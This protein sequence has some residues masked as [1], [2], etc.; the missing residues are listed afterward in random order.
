[1]RLVG[2]PRRSD[3]GKEVHLGGIAYRARDM[4][5]EGEPSFTVTSKARSW[6][7]YDYGLP[8]GQL[9]L[10]QAGSLQGFP[11]AYPWAGSRTA[12]FEQIANA[13]PPPMAAA[14]LS[15]LIDPN[16]ATP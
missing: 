15:T 7:V 3:G 16:G 2:F 14:L 5:D 9:S 8:T 11:A 1:M 13:V 4:R 10:A 6:N 12:A